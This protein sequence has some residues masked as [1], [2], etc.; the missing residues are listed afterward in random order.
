MGYNN[1][2]NN[3]EAREQV[4]WH[5]APQQAMFVAELIRKAQSYYLDGDLGKWFWTLT[6]LREINNQDLEEKERKIM[7]D[8]EAEVTK[9]LFYW[10]RY[11]KYISEQL[12]VPKEIKAGKEE[13]VRRIK[14]YQR[15][16]HDYLKELGYFPNKEDRTQL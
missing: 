1:S 6:S 5:I 11:S 8:L 2:Y 12:K 9:I 14:K 3:Y 16:V 15:Q 7:D 13:L 4:V 10:D